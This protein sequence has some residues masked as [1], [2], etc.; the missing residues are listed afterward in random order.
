METWNL[1]D[2]EKLRVK[3]AAM[4]EIPFSDDL[5]AQILARADERSHVSPS[6]RHRRG[7][8][9][10]TRGLSIA[11]GLVAAVGLLYGTWATVQHRAGGPLTPAQ[12]ATADSARGFG[13]NVA[14]LRVSNVEIGTAPGMPKS[15]IVYATLTNTS[16]RPISKV[17]VFGVLSF[18]KKSP[19]MQA[20][21]QS[22][23]WNTF[24]NAP[25]EAIP[26]G[27]TVT[28]SFRPFGAPH[29]ASDALTE[30]PTLT[31]YNAQLVPATQGD[32][33]W[34]RAPL[35]IDA[36]Q[37]LPRATF[38]TG[39]S[40]GVSVQVS[41]PSSKAVRLSDLRALIWFSQSAGQDWTTSLD[42]RFISDVATVDVK[43]DEIAA[44][45]SSTVYFRLVAG[46]NADFFSSTPNVAFI[47]RK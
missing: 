39:Q 30:S 35:H 8:S 11:A 41:N 13:L 25:D 2:E 16:Q 19:G 36:I 32:V 40:I 33:T 6:R 9:S 12:R 14:P 34:M 42:T 23:D 21:L 29:T 27:A 22:S 5:K 3:F 18:S 31:F 46:A 4:P 15:A 37:V 43:T 17:N 44:H 38:G 28:W 10:W 1:D 47:L 7:R 26:P 24:V 20:T 45:G